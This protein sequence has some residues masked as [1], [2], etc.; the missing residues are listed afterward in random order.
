MAASLLQRQ[1]GPNQLQETTGPEACPL[2][3]PAHHQEL[4]D[5]QDLEV[6]ADLDGTQAEPQVHQVCSVQG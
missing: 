1:V 5:R 4:H 6:V 2:L 3:L